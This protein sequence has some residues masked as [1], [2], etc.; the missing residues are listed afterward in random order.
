MCT[1]F[2]EILRDFLVVFKRI[3][4]ECKKR[5]RRGGFDVFI[6]VILMRR[7]RGI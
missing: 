3:D 6:K 2:W 5:M 7:G 4:F 1:G